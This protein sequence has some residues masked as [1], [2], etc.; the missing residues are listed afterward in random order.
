MGSRNASSFILILQDL[1]ERLILNVKRTVIQDESRQRG[2]Y[3][4]VTRC[5]PVSGIAWTGA[6]GLD[7]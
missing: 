7:D 4:I 1:S 3:I 2:F 6:A 5:N